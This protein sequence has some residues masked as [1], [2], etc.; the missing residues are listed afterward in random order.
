LRL[1]KIKKKKGQN[2][3]GH[4]DDI[5]DEMD[6]RDEY[7][8]HVQTVADEIWYD[9]NVVKMAHKDVNFRTMVELMTRVILSL[10]QKG[11]IP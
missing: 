7:E 2:V 6:K 8:K 4:Y 11:Y 3:V 9:P 1:K 10:Q 5:M